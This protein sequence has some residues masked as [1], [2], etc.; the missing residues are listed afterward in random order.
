MKAETGEMRDMRECVSF[1]QC[2]WSVLHSVGNEAFLG[3]FA[4]LRDYGTAISVG[5]VLLKRVGS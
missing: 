1:G 3:G 4:L 5:S 2:S